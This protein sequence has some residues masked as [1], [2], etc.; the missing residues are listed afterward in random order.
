MGRQKASVRPKQRASSRGRASRR[1]DND[2]IP[3]VYREM[4]MVAEAEARETQPLGDRPV[5]RRKVGERTAP[6][7][8]TETRGQESQSTQETKEDT[9]HLQVAF[10]YDASSDD[11]DIE[12]EDISLQQA[13]VES[14]QQPT[15]TND[16]PLQITLGPETK[17]IKKTL[18]RQKP[19]SAAEKRLRLDI[20]KTHLICLL[21]HVQ[22]RNLWCN[23]SQLQVRSSL[24]VSYVSNIMQNSLKAKLLPKR[25]I[26]LLNPPEDKEWPTRSRSFIDGLN[27]A[28]DLFGKRFKVT[29]PGMKRAHWAPNPEALK[30]KT[31][32]D[33]A[34]CCVV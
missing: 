18:P 8:A 1:Q 16:E 26:S 3:E 12:W 30:E 23:D 32:C 20:H 24:I 7:V 25:V 10:D 31:V 5:K 17:P 11:E 13:P 27:Q 28:G 9:G 2:E 21:Q 33:L 19:L 22:S 15:P 6:S 4:L 29:R 34:M 14:P